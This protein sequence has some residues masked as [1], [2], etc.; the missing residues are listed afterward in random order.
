MTTPT[1]GRAGWFSDPAGRFDNR[2]WD[3]GQWTSAVKRGEQ[4][5]SDPDS[6][7]A[8]LLTEDASSAVPGATL[9]PPPGA[10]PTPKVAP[11]AFPH[12]KS[13]DRLTSLP[14]TEAQREVVRVLP[15]AGIS[16]KAEQPGQVHAAVPFKGQANIAIIII[17]CFICIIPGVLYA[18]TASRVKM[19]PAVINLAP[20]S[21]ES[22]VI[23][24][25]APPQARQS[26][27]TAL[28]TLPW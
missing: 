3:G 14:V 2:Y 20:S 5:E 12:V 25:Q 27:L 13:G 28:G 22:T 11:P 7:P 6:L 10:S 8:S 18:M 19:Q 9:P 23:T 26:I 21:A 24:I 15:L 17:L 16:V 1:P 4:V